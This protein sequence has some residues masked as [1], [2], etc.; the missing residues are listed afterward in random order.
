MLKKS[1]IASTTAD[2]QSGAAM[3][4]SEPQGNYN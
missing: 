2:L 4:R 3:L 1:E